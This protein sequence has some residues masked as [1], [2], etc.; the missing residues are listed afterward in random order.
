MKATTLLRLLG[1]STTNPTPIK[2]IGKT[3]YVVYDVVVN[4]LTDPL[5]LATMDDCQFSALAAMDETTKPEMAKPGSGGGWSP[6]VTVGMSWN[7]YIQVDFLKK[8]RVTRITFE[9]VAGKFSVK[10]FRLQYSQSGV[11][12]SDEC[13]VEVPA[14]GEVDLPS[15]CRFNAR[16]FRLVVLA[17]SDGLGGAVVSQETKPL[18][19]RFTDWYG[20]AD[21]GGTPASC[22][23]TTK[24]TRLS[25]DVT[26]WRHVAYDS[27]NDVFYF[28]DMME[29]PDRKGFEIGCY[30]SSDGV[31][32]I[33]LPSYIGRLL[34]QHP[35]R[36]MC[37]MD[38]RDSALVCSKDGKEWSLMPDADHTDIKSQAMPPT[39]VPGVPSA[40]LA[41]ITFGDWSVDFSGVMKSGSVRARWA[42]CCG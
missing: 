19:V 11:F 18:G 17:V 42:N 7:H 9:E 21:L 40:D 36:G 24:P 3:A 12:F 15:D 34:G 30:S 23:A 10:K 4:D 5:N 28:C 22:P 2:Y 38:K 25:N 39:V 32:W 31:S 16:Y 29:R 27:T 37:A 13:E 41:P 33:V 35:D 6:P 26:Q 20:T 1:S 14:N 8:T